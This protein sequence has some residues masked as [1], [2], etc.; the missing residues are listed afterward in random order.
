MG[1]VATRRNTSS[2]VF[3]IFPIYSYLLNKQGEVRSFQNFSRALKL[4]N[5]SENN[6]PLRLIPGKSLKT[7]KSKMPSTPAKHHPPT[8]LG[9]LLPAPL[10]KSPSLQSSLAHSQIASPLNPRLMTPYN[11][12]YLKSK[13]CYLQ[14][15]NLHNTNHNNSSTQL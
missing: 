3:H 7:T 6:R 11:M 12:N 2:H 8:L 13:I 9:A 5:P 1:G 15:C 4:L 14:Q 10:T